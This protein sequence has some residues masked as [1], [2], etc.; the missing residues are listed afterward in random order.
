MLPYKYIGDLREGVEILRNSKRHTLVVDRAHRRD[1]RYRMVQDGFF[2]TDGDETLFY[3]FPTLEERES[4]PI[5][6]WW[7][8]TELS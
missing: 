2:L 4:E 3:P 1:F 6:D 8:S 5:R 7:R